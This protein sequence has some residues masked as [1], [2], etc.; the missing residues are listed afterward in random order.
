MKQFFLRSSLF[1]VYSL[2]EWEGS[3]HLRKPFL[4]SIFHHF[5]HC[6]YVIFSSAPD[7][8]QTSLTLC[9]EAKPGLSTQATP[10]VTA[11][12]AMGPRCS[13]YS[14]LCLMSLLC[15]PGAD[16]M[17]QSLCEFP[18]KGRRWPS[19]ALLLGIGY[20]CLADRDKEI[21]IFNDGCPHMNCVPFSPSLNKMTF[22]LARSVGFFP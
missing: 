2:W 12:T 11:S 14:C 5:W 7:T 9:L 21:C 1:S 6:C 19:H 18:L 13:L 22:S 4:C 15:F 10:R 8:R 20:D 3:C 16:R 17:V